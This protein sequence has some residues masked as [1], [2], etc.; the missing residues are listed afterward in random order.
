MHLLTQTIKSQRT[1]LGSGVESS[2]T[3]D[4]VMASGKSMVD[5]LLTHQHQ[6]PAVG[7]S[8]GVAT[9][10]CDEGTCTCMRCGRVRTGWEGV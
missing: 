10:S 1:R 9:K 4:E 5:L 7:G 8:V 6:K 2:I 3:S